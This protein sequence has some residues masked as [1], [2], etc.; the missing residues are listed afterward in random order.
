M[1]ARAIPFLGAV[2]LSTLCGTALMSASTD[3]YTVWPDAAAGLVTIGWAAILTIQRRSGLLAVSFVLAPAAYIAPLVIDQRDDCSEC[4]V[5][6]LVIL[7]IIACAVAIAVGI[8]VGSA[9]NAMAAHGRSG[10]RS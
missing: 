2:W 10:P 7:V 9:W 4:Y 8:A 6:L 3:A 5:E 1:P